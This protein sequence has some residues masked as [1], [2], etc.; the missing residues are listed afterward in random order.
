MEKESL[1]LN[2]L[3]NFGK[4]YSAEDALKMLGEFYA[5]VESV[6]DRFPA[7]RDFKGTVIFKKVDYQQAPCVQMD[8]NDG[9]KFIQY[10]NIR[11]DGKLH[12]RVG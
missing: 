5:G 3:V 4:P 12:E 2:E 7:M 10:Y 11:N 8:L 9:D 1:G 6:L